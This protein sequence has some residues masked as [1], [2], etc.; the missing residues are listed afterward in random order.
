MSVTGYVDRLRQPRIKLT[1]KGN[2][3]SA[4]IEPV[5]DTGFNG[6]LSLPVAIAIPLGLELYGR[7]PVELA[8]GLMKNELVFLGSVIWRGQERLIKI[9]LTESKAALIGSGLLQGQKLDIDYVN[10][11][12]N[13]ELVTV[14]KRGNSKKRK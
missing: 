14:T 9:F 5:V 12:V 2:R 3:Q 8:D 11:I 7:I 4:R 1:V 6:A 13:I 10:C